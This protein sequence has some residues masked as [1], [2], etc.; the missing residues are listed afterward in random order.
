MGPRKGISEAA[1]RRLIALHTDLGSKGYIRQDNVPADAP[2]GAVLYYR[3]ASMVP[4]K[5]A[6]IC[7]LDE[8]PCVVFGE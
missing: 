2:T 7:Q 5:R 3:Q 4:G 8:L 1:V 6:F